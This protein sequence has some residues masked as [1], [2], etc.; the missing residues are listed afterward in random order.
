[1]RRDIIIVAVAMAI[2]TASA[3]WTTVYFI[4]DYLAP[5]ASILAKK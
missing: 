1:V 3:I 4:D 5:Y 2:A